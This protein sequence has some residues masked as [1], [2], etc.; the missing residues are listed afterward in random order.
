MS[1]IQSNQLHIDKLL[2]NVAINYRPTTGFAARVAPIVGVQKQSDLYRVWNQADLWGIDSTLRAPGNEANAIDVRVGSDSY[3][4]INYALAADVTIETIANADNRAEIEAGR[5]MSLTGKLMLDW[6]KRV[7]DLVTTA[8]NVSSQHSVASGWTD[9][10]NSSPFDDIN[11]VMD[12]QQDNT[13]YRPNKMLIGGEAYRELRRNNAIIDK[14]N[15]T[16]VTGG[17]MNSTQRQI[18]DLFE[19]E[20]VIVGEGYYNSAAEGQ[21][22]KLS[23]LMGDHVLLYYAPSVVSIEL[24]S[25]MYSFRWSGN[26][27][28]NMQVQRMEGKPWRGVA[29][30]LQAGYYQDEK[31]VSSDLGALISWTGCSQ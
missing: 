13:G 31:I 28:P 20:E 7:A 30:R 10:S 8:T 23:R 5:V 14:S 12:L 24:P 2:S 4:A 27:L 22:I 21:P 25:Y 29:N 3:N 15:K 17:D 6:D 16:G 11:A 1:F 19:L 18:A 9:H 26:G